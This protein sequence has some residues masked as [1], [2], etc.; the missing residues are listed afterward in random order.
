[1]YEC[2]IKTLNYRKKNSK[3]NILIRLNDS[4]PKQTNVSIQFK[5]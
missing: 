4:M 3:I 5:S 2:H 1:M